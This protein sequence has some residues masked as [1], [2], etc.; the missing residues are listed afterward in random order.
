MTSNILV[1]RWREQSALLFVEMNVY[2]HDVV[3]CISEIN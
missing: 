2:E 3:M 1:W